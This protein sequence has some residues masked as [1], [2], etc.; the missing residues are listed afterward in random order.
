[1]YK[2][3]RKSQAKLDT[4]HDD[5]KKICNELIK[6]M[7]VTVLEGVRTVEQQE[8][9]VRTGKSQTMKSKHLPQ[10]DGL[11]HAV[12]LAPYPIDWNNMNRFYY[13]QGL[14]KGIAS[15]LGIKVRLG[16][17]W[18]GDGET[19]DHSFVDGPHFELDD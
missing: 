8:E 6:V 10:E 11:S 14:I 4:C 1:M 12:D 18:D 19:K 3:S 15:Q 16:I 5:I 9:Y 13:M 2:F 17:D 7:D